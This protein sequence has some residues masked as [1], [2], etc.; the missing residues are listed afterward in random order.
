MNRVPTTMSSSGRDMVL[1]T[2]QHDDAH[3]RRRSFIVGLEVTHL[4]A[5]SAKR[6][7]CGLLFHASH[8]ARCLCQDTFGVGVF[9]RNGAG[10]RLSEEWNV[11]SEVA[12]ATDCAAGVGHLIAQRTDCIGGG[13]GSVAMSRRFPQSPSVS[14][15]AKCR[16]SVQGTVPALR[17][18][19][20]RVQSRDESSPHP[21]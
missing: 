15:L 14:M 1:P 21:Y 9:Q 4:A 18:R 13:I 2:S 5:R 10:G 19:T 16:R 6:P 11:F 7:H 17:W 20:G 3:R 12:S 8:H